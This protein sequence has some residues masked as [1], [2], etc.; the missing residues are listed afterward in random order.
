MSLIVTEQ[1]SPEAGCS[2][3]G[4][5]G[6]VVTG[7]FCSWLNHL[8]FVL[9]LFASLLQDGCHRSEH[10]ILIQSCSKARGKYFLLFSPD[11]ALF[12]FFSWGEKNFPESSADIS[13]LNQKCVLW[14]PLALRGVEREREN[15][16]LFQSQ[17]VGK[18]YRLWRWDCEWLWVSSQ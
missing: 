7:L 12:F 10:H 6:S 14:L 2:E 16:W 13:S 1:K 3:V 17:N 18:R 8:D 9:K 4:S 15:I 5:S 11:S